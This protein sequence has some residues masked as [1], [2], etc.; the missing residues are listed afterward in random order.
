MF[1]LLTFIGCALGGVFRYLGTLMIARFFGEGF[2]WGTLFVNAVGSFLFGLFLGSGFAVKEL[3]LSSNGYA[4]VALGFCGGFT[5]FSTFSLQTFSLI[6]K[7]AW[8]KALANIFGSVSLC[9]FCVF[10]GYA[11]G[12]GL[13]Q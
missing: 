6:S 3:W 12:E 11:M 13:T 10:S 7:Q 9:V 4:F 2:P 1:I 8:G 5:T